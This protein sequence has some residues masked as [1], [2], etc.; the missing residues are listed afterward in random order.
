MPH[1][2]AKVFTDTEHAI[3]GYFHL[4]EQRALGQY[5]ILGVVNGNP[6]NACPVL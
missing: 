3:V 2:K 5:N 4:A 1:A 6:S